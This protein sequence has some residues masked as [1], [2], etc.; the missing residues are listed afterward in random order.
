MPRGKE[1]PLISQ[2]QDKY[3]KGRLTR[4]QLMRDAALF[5]VSMSS[6]GFFLSGITPRQKGAAWDLNLSLS[7]AVSAH[8][9]ADA[10]GAIILSATEERIEA[11]A[12]SPESVL[13]I[14]L[15]PEE[16]PVSITV[17][18]V[19]SQAIEPKVSVSGSEN[20]L[21][22]LNKKVLSP[23]AIEL[24]LR[25]GSGPQRIDLYLKEELLNDPLTFALVGDNQGNDDTFAKIIA[26]INK[27]EAS[28]LIHLGDMV[29]SGTEREYSDFMDT[30]SALE[31]P[32]YSVPGNHD[33][34][35]EGLTYYETLLAPGYY[36]FHLKEYTYIFLDTSLLGMD[37][38]Q[39]EWMKKELEGRD[40]KMLF[41]HIPFLDPRGRGHSFLDQQQAH[42]I[43]NYIQEDTVGVEGVFAGHIHLYHQEEMEGILYAISGGGGATLYAPEDKGGFH[44]YSLVNTAQ[45]Q[46][47]ITAYPVE[48]PSRPREILVS[49]R[50]LDLEI[51]QDQLMEMASVE[52]KGEFQNLHGNYRGQGL[53]YGIPISKLVELT[54]GMEEEDLLLVHSFDGYIQEFPYQNV[55][56]EEAGWYE[57]Q[58][59]MVLAVMYNGQSI[60]EW[61]EGYRIAFLPEDGVFDNENYKQISLEGEG[62]YE[63]PSAGSRWIKMVQ[64]LEVLPWEKK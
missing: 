39:K 1:H 48:A 49:G 46:L 55:Y 21:A 7:D 3:L 22:L 14:L 29:P 27:T 31:I 9:Q 42:S 11:R 17:D 57:D 13:K 12:Y 58:G 25:G 40:K 2:L 4:R 6:I 51:P 63:Y 19:F 8:L 54:G 28:F 18:N 38:K 36:S 23:T 10:S 53:Y 24:K 16:Q 32:F 43:L 20:E 61:T 33:V 37:S 5:G 47:D 41:M 52:K 35:A 15:Q 60:P 50:E 44:H 34:R 26:E 64:R 62:W 30:I 45:D 56:P 59:E